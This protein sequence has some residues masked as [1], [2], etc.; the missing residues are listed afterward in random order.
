MEATGVF[1]F[2][3][4]TIIWFVLNVFNLKGVI[5][6]SRHQPVHFMAIF[7]LIW[8]RHQPFQCGLISELYKLY[9][10]VLWYAVVRK[11]EVQ[12]PGKDTSLERY[13][14]LNDNVGHNAA[15]VDNLSSLQKR[16]Q[17]PTTHR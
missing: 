5:V 11:E 10:G 6:T 4:S 13:N 7:G 9:G 15:H 12:K 2:L 8:V 14:G 1:S 17:T 16:I 3:K